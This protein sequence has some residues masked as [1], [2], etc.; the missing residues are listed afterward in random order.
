MVEHAL[1]G[2]F[3]TG[4]PW[5]VLEV[6]E[7][8]LTACLAFGHTDTAHYDEGDAIAGGLH[9]P[10]TRHPSRDLSLFFFGVQVGEGGWLFVLLRRLAAPAF[11]FVGG[12]V[13]PL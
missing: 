10:L 2:V 13:L 12:I 9:T 3:A 5:Q 8:R 6:L 7:M 1:L 4:V 11:L